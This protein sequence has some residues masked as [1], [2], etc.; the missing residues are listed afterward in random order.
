VAENSWAKPGVVD[1]RA[2]IYG[3]KGHTRADLLRGSA[4]TTYSDAGYG[5]AVEKASSTTGWTFTTFEETWN[6][7]F[8][9][10]MQHFVNC[11][12]GKETLIESGEDGREVL[13]IILAAYRS[14][15]EGRRITFPHRPPRFELPV[16][17][18]KRPRR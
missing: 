9:Q 2:E 12:R 15:G 17:L 11:V 7:G 13:R 10:E 8:P 3:S 4:L 5:Y 14:A 6:Y 1:D 16:D 18:W